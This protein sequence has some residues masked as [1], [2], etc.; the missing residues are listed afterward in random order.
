MVVV[1]DLV[2][3]T[4]VIDQEIFQEMVQVMMKKA[5]AAVV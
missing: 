4:V 5:S 1:K 2:V 3:I